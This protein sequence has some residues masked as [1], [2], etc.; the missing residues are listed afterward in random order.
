MPENAHAKF[1]FKKLFRSL[2]MMPHVGYEQGRWESSYSDT[3]VNST[4]YGDTIGLRYGFLAGFKLKKYFYIAGSM[5]WGSAIWRYNEAE[6]FNYDDDFESTTASRSSIGAMVGVR[7]TKKS[8]FWV[9]YD[10]E[11]E[12]ELSENHDPELSAPT[13]S[14][15]AIKFGLTTNRKK[16]LFNLFYQLDS[17]DE[18]AFDDGEPS[19]LP[20]RSGRFD[21]GEFK[22]S[23]FILS[24]SYFWGRFK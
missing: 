4:T 15:T 1:K 12:L 8:I 6:D 16:V 3:V 18:I 11:N 14:G 20:I 5:S 9:G 24:I 13:Y 10:F 22:H 21:L 17:F 2:F 7:L 23:S 19:E